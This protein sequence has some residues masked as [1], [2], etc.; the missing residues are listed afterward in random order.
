MARK[1]T[2]R[3]ASKSIA[4]KAAPVKKK[5]RVRLATPVGR[6]SF[7]HLAEPNTTGEYPT[8]KY[9]VDLIVSKE[10]MKSAEGKSLISHVK[11]A[12]SEA[13]GKTFTSVWDIP[14]TPFADLDDK[15]DPQEFEKGCIRIRAKGS[16][17]RAPIVI[18]GQKQKLDEE[19][20]AAIKGGDY[21]RLVVSPY[22]YTKG[23]G[24]VSFNLDVAQFWKEG[25]AFGQGI[26][27]SIEVLDEMEVPLEDL[28]EET[29]DDSEDAEEGGD[30]D[31]D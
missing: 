18:D 12:A 3:I 11:M 13:L 2:A 30:L 25:D 21:G 27:A 9:Q 19:E 29:V 5:E 26:Q 22:A 10:D 31:F 14:Q 24:G 4:A 17:D 15:E 8:G 28:E 16:A 7:P 6:F 20:V 23:S 1:T